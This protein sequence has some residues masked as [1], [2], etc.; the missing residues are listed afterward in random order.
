MGAERSWGARVCLKAD[1]PTP[2]AMLTWRVAVWETPEIREGREKY[3]ENGK[4]RYL[5]G[6]GWRGKC[7]R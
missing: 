1:P 4:E 3:P 7:W 5:R 6:E 2:T